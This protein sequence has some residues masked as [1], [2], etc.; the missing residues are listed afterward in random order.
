VHASIIGDFGEGYNA[1]NK[2][3]YNVFQQE[4]IMRRVM[5]D[6]PYFY[7]SKVTDRQ[8]WQRLSLINDVK[9]D[10]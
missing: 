9:C 7:R 3:A 6:V 1:G 5:K 4:S 10:S 2:Q 8:V